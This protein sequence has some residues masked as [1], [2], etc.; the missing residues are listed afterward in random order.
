MNWDIRWRHRISSRDLA[1][2]SGQD[3]FWEIKR[4][5]KLKEETSHLH[6]Q[7]TGGGLKDE[8]S[9]DQAAQYCPGQA[10][11]DCQ[12]PEQQSAGSGFVHK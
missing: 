3:W 5:E 7:E 8:Q 6:S 11:G 4:Q 10:D 1:L 12:E 9:A 2:I